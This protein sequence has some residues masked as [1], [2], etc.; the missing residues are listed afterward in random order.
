MPPRKAPKRARTETDDEESQ[1][2]SLKKSK[3]TIISHQPENPQPT[4]KVLPVHISFPPRTPDTLRIATWNICGWAASH[5][6][7]FKYYVEAE[8]ADI[9][10]LTETK[11][12]EQPVDPALDARYPYTYWSISSKK[13]YSGTA[14]L[15]KHKPLSVTKTLPNH[16]N[17]DLVKGRIITLEFEGYY[18]IGTYVVNAGVEL[19]TLEDKKEWNQHFENYI[20][21]LDKVK[22]VIWTGDLNVAPT[23]IDLANAKRNWN[24]T[25]GYTEAET[26]SF[27][28]ILDPP[29]DVDAGK[30]VDVWRQLH[31]KDQHYTY[32]SYRFNCRLKGL[33]WR[34]DMFVLSERIA[35]RVKMCEIRSEIYGASDHCPVVVEVEG[36]AQS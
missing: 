36:L 13:S 20:R 19:K 25:P 17:P 21:D 4:N 16:P 27:K 12:N 5:K 33:G 6:K 35:E 1:P 30:F 7:G 24:K 28:N 23:A 2:S 26:S 22:P 15:S 34:L 8:D 31:P 3:S 32:F 29:E 9:L 14:I 18:L 11:V 10:V